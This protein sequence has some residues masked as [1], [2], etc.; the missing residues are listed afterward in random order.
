MRPSAQLQQALGT[1][2][3]PIH[4]TCTSSSMTSEIQKIETWKEQNS[5]T[6]KKRGKQKLGKLLSEMQEVL[7]KT[8]PWDG[9]LLHKTM[10][11]D[12][13]LTNSTKTI[14]ETLQSTNGFFSS[15]ATQVGTTGFI[16]HFSIQP[17]CN[18][19][20]PSPRLKRLPTVHSGTECISPLP[21]GGL[22]AIPLHF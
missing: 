21:N 12:P 20:W 19:G 16:V 8:G 15:I 2:T 14:T 7:V 1:T 17:R 10:F 5:W 18:V 9:T 3:R 11:L 22:C 4:V 6:E 13:E